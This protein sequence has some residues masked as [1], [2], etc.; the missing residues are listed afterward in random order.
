MQKLKI[1]VSQSLMIS[2]GILFGIGVQA[3]VL[4]FVTGYTDMTW[5]WY[6]P[7]SIVL[8]GILCALPTVFLLSM[9]GLSKAK[10]WIRIGLHFVS[11][12]LVVTL[13]GRLFRWYDSFLEYL[14]ILV[15]YV[16]IYI[17]VWVCSGWMAKEDA[18][19]IND[20]IESIRDEE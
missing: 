19:K 10:T 15:M 2:T 12:G 18:R 4:H 5:P 14:P 7:L 17:F 20:A 11:V 16:L 3:M 9:D 6:I 8:T 1:I 13:C